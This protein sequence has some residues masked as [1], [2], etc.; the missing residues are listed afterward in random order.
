MSIKYRNSNF[1]FKVVKSK[2][3]MIQQG[4]QKLCLEKFKVP[5]DKMKKEQLPNDTMIMRSRQKTTK[6]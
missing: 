6:R 1:K 2:I 4:Y 5:I 3:K